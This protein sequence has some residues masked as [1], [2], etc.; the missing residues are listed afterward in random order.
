PCQTCPCPPGGS[1]PG[2]LGAGAGP[3][4]CTTCTT[5]MGGMP[6][7]NV[8]E[9]DT[10]LALYDKP[11]FYQSALGGEFALMLAYRQ[12]ESRSSD[13]S[14]P[15]FGPYWS[16]GWVE[17]VDVKPDSGVTDYSAYSATNLVGVGGGGW[18][19]FAASGRGGSSRDPRT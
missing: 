19:Y 3:G 11:L 1:G 2:G 4:P 16:G 17:F 14:V 10:S 12:R 6:I 15:N 7:W 9:P 18:S 8:T 5:Q 13:N